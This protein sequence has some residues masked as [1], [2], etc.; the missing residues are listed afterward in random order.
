M[1]GEA[2]DDA[3]E[4]VEISGIATENAENTERNPGSAY[5]RV[6]LGSDLNGS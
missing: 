3:S 4:R 2:F 5:R 6:A 1:G